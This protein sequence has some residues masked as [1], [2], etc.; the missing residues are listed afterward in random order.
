[1]KLLRPKQRLGF[2]YAAN[3]AALFHRDTGTLALTDSLVNVPK[4]ATAVYEPSNLLAI[5]DNDRESGSLGTFI[6][7]AAKAVNAVNAVNVVGTRK[8]SQH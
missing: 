2:G 6:L 1:M 3:E 4:R 7:K 5:G 8:P